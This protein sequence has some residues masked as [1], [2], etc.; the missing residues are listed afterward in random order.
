M[1][2]K[3]TSYI[4]TFAP[5]LV[6]ALISWLAT[7]GFAIDGELQSSL[8]ILTTALL[9]GLYYSVARLI[10]SRFPKTEK[11]LLGS[12]KTPTYEDS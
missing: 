8:I 7:K 6:G 3:V 1:S 10:G 4:R 11:F 9:Q 5:I 2:D 12:S